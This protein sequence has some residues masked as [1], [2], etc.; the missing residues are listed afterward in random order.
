MK[1]FIVLALIIIAVIVSIVV[2]NIFINSSSKS[3]S[4]AEKEAALAKI[5]GRKPNLSEKQVSKGNLEYKGKYVSFLYP[6]AGS[7]YTPR[8]N[9]QVEKDNWNLD[10]FSFDLD[11]PRAR[12]LVTVSQAPNGVTSINDYPGVKLR[13]IQ[14]GI[15]QQKDIFVSAH[16]GFVFDRQDNSGFEKTAFFYWDKKIYIFSILGNDLKAVEDVFNTIITSAKFL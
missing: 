4:Q 16:S 13:Q 8:F 1:K 2:F 7:I 12:V 3:L 9:G 11:N 15:Y 10:S 14:S 5:L 6:A